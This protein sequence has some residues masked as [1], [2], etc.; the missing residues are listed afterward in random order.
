[1]GFLYV[2]SEWIER[3]EPP[4]LDLHS[5]EWTGP[6]EYRI[7]DDAR[8]FETW[9]QNFAGKAGFGA[10]VD[11]CLGW[12]LPDIWDR[13]SRLG[14]DLRARLL[15][16]PGVTVHDRGRD[17]GAIVTF[18]VAGRRPDEIKTALRS[19]AVNVSTV[20]PA[21]ARLDMDRRRLDGLVRASVHYF[22]TEA[23][24][25]RLGQ[26]IERIGS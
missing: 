26:E 22:N 9:E 20:T 17:P 7:R 25:D 2:R 3:L 4:V 5:A 1:M 6:F 19:E 23:E 11:Y 18:T 13:V 8:R 15:R 24:L 14:R 16:V 10:A 12:G 21:A